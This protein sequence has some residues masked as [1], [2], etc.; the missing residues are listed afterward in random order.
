M[1]LG[2]HLLEDGCCAA[3][4]GTPKNKAV[5]I[6]PDVAERGASDRRAAVGMHEGS[7][8]T[9][10]GN[11]K[12]VPGNRRLVALV[13][14]VCVVLLKTLVSQ[15]AGSRGPEVRQEGRVTSRHGHLKSW[16]HKDLPKV[17][18]VHPTELAGVEEEVGTSSVQ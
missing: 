7:C 10:R 4:V 5:E 6:K 18:L 17:R 1:A 12:Y 13:M 9:T 14:G 15:G 2:L 3:G 16:Q 8:L 11:T